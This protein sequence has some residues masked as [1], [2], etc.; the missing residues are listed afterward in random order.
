MFWKLLEASASTI[1]VE[2]AAKRESKQYMNAFEQRAKAHKQ[3]LPE[4]FL[5]V[6]TR[7]SRKLTVA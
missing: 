3:K 1:A 2:T 7:M 6:H 5:V 4:H